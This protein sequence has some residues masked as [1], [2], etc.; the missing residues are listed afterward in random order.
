[1]P[2]LAQKHCSRGGEHK[3]VNNDSNITCNSDPVKRWSKSETDSAKTH[4]IS[5]ELAEI[6]E[7]WPELPE[8][9]K[10]TIR[11][12]ITITAKKSQ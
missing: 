9:I 6:I 8:H 5:P 10:Q 7:V 11:T 1:M 3:S 4:K 12:L 2:F